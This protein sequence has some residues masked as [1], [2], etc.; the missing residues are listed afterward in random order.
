MSSYLVYIVLVAQ[1]IAFS[2]S[3]YLRIPCSNYTN[4]KVW[5]LSASQPAPAAPRQ[6]LFTSAQAGVPFPTTGA[7][8]I[9]DAALSD[10]PANLYY[11]ASGPQGPGAITGSATAATATPTTADES[12]TTGTAGASTTTSD[13]RR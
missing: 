9:S 11:M 13:G 4:S 2:P 8:S 12:S 10:A 6:A 7:T 5:I 3:Y 1:A